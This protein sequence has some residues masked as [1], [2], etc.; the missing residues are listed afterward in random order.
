M[1]VYKNNETAVVVVGDM[2]SDEIS[3]FNIQLEKYAI[4][5]VRQST[6]NCINFDTTYSPGI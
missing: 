6:R 5:S 3:N 1:I 4:D 2:P